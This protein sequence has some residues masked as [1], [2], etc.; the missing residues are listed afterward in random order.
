M[1]GERLTLS[2]G[3][4]QL[5]SLGGVYIKFLQLV[6]VNIDGKQQDN[7][8]ALLKVYEDT[9]PDDFDVMEYLRHERIDVSR[10]ARIESKPFATGSFGQVYYAT[11][12]TGEEVV[13]KL[14][15]P[16]IMK[17]LQYDLRLLGLL[18]WV[19]RIIDRQG[20]ID[21][22]SVYVEFR[23]TSLAETDYVREARVTL[24]FYE[25]YRDHAHLVIPFTHVELSNR[26][27]IVQERVN[28]LS[29]A[30]LLVIQ[31]QGISSA[32][33]V[34][35]QLNS[36]IDKQLYTVGYEFLSRVIRGEVVHG[37]PHPG[38]I[39]LLPDDRVALIDF[40]IVAELRSGRQA[41]Y[42]LM[43]QYGSLYS[44]ELKLD[45]FAFAAFKFLAPKLHSAITQAPA[46]LR[47]GRTRQA[48]LM[49]SL[50]EAMHQVIG[51]DQTN[52]QIKQL[53]RNR[54]IM[55]VMFFA[56]NRN[57]RFGFEFD[58]DAAN[59]L[60]AIQAFT[61]V[62]NQFDQIGTAP[63]VTASIMDAINDGQHHLA[64]I[65]DV[66]STALTPAEAV[67]TLS[68]WFDK[69]ARNDPWIAEQVVS[70]YMQ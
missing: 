48:D 38:N 5:D 37:D 56:I 58:L 19:Y 13:I 25:R 55:K 61:M 50:S 70:G 45:E 69:M 33:Y 64:E 46:V 20:M 67:E 68:L 6:V 66:F 54:Q 17:Y 24:D 7:Y 31:A 39:L 59:V 22:R 1:S 34:R 9:D 35:T 36:D 14:L 57:N 44:G 32:D 8:E 49:S 21:F 51:E 42:E 2:R 29:L 43:T 15:R 23:K 30:K 18:S 47:D 28:G 53:L 11:L 65:N 41:F 52:A 60:K 63:V 27:V 26:H 12:A 40:G 3:Y 10:F 62:A 16:S 4:E